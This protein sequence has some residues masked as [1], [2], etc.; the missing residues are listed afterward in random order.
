[1]V[2]GA[3]NKNKH[4]CTASYQEFFTFPIRAEDDFFIIAS[5]TTM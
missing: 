1:M 2:T 3:T 4:A 5:Y